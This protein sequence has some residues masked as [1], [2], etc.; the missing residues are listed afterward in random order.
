MNFGC[1]QGELCKDRCT[2]GM[3]QF[4]FFFFSPA[5]F[6]STVKMSHDIHPLKILKEAHLTL[7]NLYHISTFGLGGIYQPNYRRHPNW[8]CLNEVNASTSR[9]WRSLSARRLQL[10]AGILI[11]QTS[12]SSTSPSSRWLITWP[13]RLR[14]RS[15]GWR[16]MGA[17]CQHLISKPTQPPF[18]PI[19]TCW[20]GGYQVRGGVLDTDQNK[21][22][23]RNA[24]WC[25]NVANGKWNCCL[26]RS[27]PLSLPP[28]VH[29]TICPSAAEKRSRLG[30][31]SHLKL[32]GQLSGGVTSDPQGRRLGYRV[33][34]W[35]C[36]WP[37]FVSMQRA[38]GGLPWPGQPCLCLC[39]P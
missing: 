20:Y 35:Q 8:R 24:C 25:C 2:F 3:I 6:L 13:F 30:N 1:E 4:L 23:E 22:G 32:L 37:V 9:Q 12:R 10:P 17:K 21:L 26:F 16:R 11:N 34:T 18:T 36:G 31:L 5:H 14:E 7:W 38:T 15:G 19:Q 29:L 28:S 27:V 39:M 33:L